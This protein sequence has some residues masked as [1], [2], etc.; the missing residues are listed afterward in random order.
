[1]VH[2]L[3]TSYILPGGKRFKSVSHTPMGRGMGSVLLTGGEGGP[4]SASS[5]FGLD[6][7]IKQTNK[8]P[9]LYGMGLQ[10]ITPKLEGLNIQG[11]G[12]P[13]IKNIKL[14]I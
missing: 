9:S 4:G 6:D 8:D 11:R 13:K 1:M 14:S 12:K 10:K 5:Y 2:N 3:T 7:Y